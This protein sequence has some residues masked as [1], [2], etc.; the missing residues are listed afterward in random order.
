MLF[1]ICM[2]GDWPVFI[3]PL[4]FP[5]RLSSCIRWL[6]V[7]VL[8]HSCKQNPLGRV[9]KGQIL[10]PH[11]QTCWFRK[12]RFRPFGCAFIKLSGYSYKEQEQCPLRN[13]G[14]WGH[15]NR[16]GWPLNASI[17]ECLLK[18]VISANEIPQVLQGEI[19]H[20]VTHLLSLKL[21]ESTSKYGS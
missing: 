13:T 2:G 21:M 3:L 20:Y 11:P 17:C 1:K 15:E 4:L 16:E 6:T 18:C 8:R 7:T 5:T 9:L 19:P 14:Q 10:G 12:S